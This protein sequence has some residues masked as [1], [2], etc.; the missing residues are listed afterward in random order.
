MADLQQLRRM[1]EHN[2]SSLSA[3]EKNALIRARIQETANARTSTRDSA[4]DEMDAIRRGRRVTEARLT[5]DYDPDAYLSPSGGGS[6][7]FRQIGDKRLV[8]RKEL[9][10]ALRRRI[11]QTMATLWDS[12]P[13]SRRMAERLVNYIVGDEVKVQ[14][15][16]EDDGTKRAIQGVIDGFWDDRRN[17]L[18]DRLAP[19]L[20]GLF[21]YGELALA[22]TVNEATGLVR[23]AYISPDQV[24]DVK[25][26]PDDI[27]HL[28]KLVVAP[29]MGASATE[30]DNKSFDVVRPDET[31]PAAKHYGRLSGEAFFWAVN[32]LPDMVRGRPTG[33]AVADLMDADEQ[34]TWNSVERSGLANA[35]VWD[36]T[37]KGTD[38]KGVDTWLAK[39]GGVPKPGSVVAHNE[40]VEWKPLSVDL[41]TGETVQHHDLL[42][43]I[44]ALAHGM[45]AM[46]FTAASDPNRANG[47]NLTGPTL[48]DMTAAQKT[49]RAVINGLVA[50]QLDAAVKAG[51]LPADL[52]TRKAFTVELPELSV[53]DTAAGAT[54]LSTLVAAVQ[55]ATQGE[56]PLISTSLGRRLV[57]MAVKQMGIEVDTAEEEQEL[58]QQGAENKAKADEAA[59]IY[60][61]ADPAKSPPPPPAPGNKNK[62]GKAAGPGG[63]PA[64]RGKL[65]A[66]PQRG[67]AATARSPAGD[68]VRQAIT[69]RGG[70]RKAAGR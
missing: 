25:T 36:V 13:L 26:E 40:S 31:D 65:V 56:Q 27:E 44:A 62:D 46:W 35:F 18:D 8:K 5:N 48:R 58:A 41:K 60:G 12:N 70:E 24:V 19:W 37:L 47:E 43:G 17:R 59:A 45:P 42:V 15:Q 57:G 22:A 54:A 28:L 50:F 52:D 4:L 11:L 23:L 3:E 9:P 67:S 64:G 69:G 16:H 21:Y 38:D 14:A 66:M 63:R 53:T 33:L 7:Y 55:L 10:E 32:R 30:H 29:S 51:L 61:Q 1:A 39:N 68:R 2:P 34:I 6:A 49:A 20:V